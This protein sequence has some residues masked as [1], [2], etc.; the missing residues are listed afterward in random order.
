[1]LALSTI[2]KTKVGDVS[3]A[4]KENREGGDTVVVDPM[5]DAV[6]GGYNIDEDMLTVRIKNIWIQA[7]S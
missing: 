3:S 2:D 1:M 7:E 4:D 5:E 6:V